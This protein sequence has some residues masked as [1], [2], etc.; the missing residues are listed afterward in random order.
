MKTPAAKC[1]SCHRALLSGLELR[2][3]ERSSVPTVHLHQTLEVLPPVDSL[4]PQWE[5]PHPW[6]LFFSCNNVQDV[7]RRVRAKEALCSFGKQV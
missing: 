3:G 1:L 4:D 5:T 6:P 7:E 2:F